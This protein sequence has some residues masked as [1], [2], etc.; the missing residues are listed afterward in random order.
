M[1]TMKWLS[2]SIVLRNWVLCGSRVASSEHSVEITY[3]LIRVRVTVRGLGLGLAL[4]LTL[5]LTQP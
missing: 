2:S 5:T 4:A 3:A 1:S